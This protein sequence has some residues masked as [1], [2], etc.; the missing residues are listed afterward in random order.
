MYQLKTIYLQ[1]KKDHNLSK[2]T[3][4]MTSAV[5]SHANINPL[6]RTTFS[7][8]QETE[9]CKNPHLL[10]YRKGVTQDPKRFTGYTVRLKMK[11]DI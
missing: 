1:C 3:G 8:A 10:H 5:L 9:G 7:K 4:T 2:K 11:S 6:H